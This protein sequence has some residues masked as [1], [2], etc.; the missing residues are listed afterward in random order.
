M[1]LKVALHFSLIMIVV[2]A[3]PTL[4]ALAQDK[5]WRIGWLD[6]SSPPPADRPSRNLEAFQRGLG[7]L[8]Y[9]K[10]RNYV[11]DARFADTDRSRL[12]ALAKEL[13]DR[14]VDV[15]VTIGTPT[16]RAAKE[17]T[18]TIPIIMAG[19]QN[20]VENGFISSLAHPGGNVTGLTHNPGPDFAGKS[21]QLLKETAPHISRVAILVALDGGFS[22]SVEVQ[23]AIAGEL[24]VTL[25]V[26]DISDAKSIDDFGAI[27]SKIME[28]DADALFVFPEFVVAK[29]KD[30]LINFASTNKL[31]SMFQETRYV[32]EGGLLS[33]YTDFLELRRR[34][35]SYVDKIF[36]G[37]KPANLPVEQPSRFE[38]VVNL[39]TAKVLGLT[40]PPSVLALAEKV[41]D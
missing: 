14:S 4:H 13:T 16:V 28:E 9:E 11:I 20:P 29:Y 36:K 1:M 37:V 30:A 18:A 33:Y 27:L 23:R 22:S 41:L 38:L 17:A 24:N 5:I 2:S 35:A 31:P 40:I 34:A 21:L 39:K 15:I 7:E 26:H 8:S 3:L 6:L 25:L 10:G 19:S 32:E 12:S